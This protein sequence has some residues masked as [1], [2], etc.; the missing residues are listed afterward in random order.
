MNLHTTDRYDDII[1]LPHH[2]SRTHPPLS[3]HQR[4]AQFM[5]FAALSGYEDI[6]RETG[7]TLESRAELESD[8]QE[9][10][11]R[12]LNTVISRL[13]QRTRVSISYFQ[14]DDAREDTDGG[15]YRSVD[16]E[17]TG[18]RQ[19]ARALVMQDGAEISCDNI[20]QLDIREHENSAE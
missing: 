8:A 4:A 7:R 15:A 12:R 5:P 3:M 20:V 9:L 13:P 11:N 17:V 10:L 1:D 14:P 2:R 18:Y 19:S 16:G 6:L